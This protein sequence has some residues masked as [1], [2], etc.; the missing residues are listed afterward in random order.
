MLGRYSIFQVRLK[1]QAD[2][3]NMTPPVLQLPAQPWEL[4][5]AADQAGLEDG[6]PLTGW[7]EQYQDFGDLAFRIPE[8]YHD[9]LTLNDLAQRL[10]DL[11]ENQQIAFHGLVQMEPEC[12]ISLEHLRDLAAS[13]DCCRIVPSA[14][15]DEQLGR[16]YVENR[17]LPELGI[18]SDKSLEQMDFKEIGQ[19]IREKVHPGVFVPSGRVDLG[20]YVAQVQGLVQAPPLPDRI[21]MP[22]YIFQFRNMKDRSILMLPIPL[23]QMEQLQRNQGGETKFQ[24]I[25]S[26][27]PSRIDPF[28]EADDLNPLNK[29]AQVIKATE[30]SG[31]LIKLK[32]VLAA[33]NSVDVDDMIQCAK[34]LE[35]YQLRTV[36]KV[37]VSPG[38]ESNGVLTDYGLLYRLDGQPIQEAAEGPIWN[39][40]EMT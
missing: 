21:T 40:M 17:G 26:A 5:D 10:T 12:Y 22:N 36:P 13:V 24:L 8:E 29:L 35:Q 16:S 32:A 1:M 14:T 6:I 19:Y 11:D 39:G 2:P 18:P 33:T 3:Y 25:D 28:V 37:T 7:I 4:V 30:Q 27:V 9:L 23:D 20:G 15:S 34:D 38:R 31:Q